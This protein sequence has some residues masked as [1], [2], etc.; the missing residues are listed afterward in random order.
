MVEALE[1]PEWVISHLTAI[2]GLVR[3][4]RAQ[5]IPSIGAAGTSERISGAADPSES[6]PLRVAALDEAD[7]LWAVMWEIVDEYLDRD[8]EECFCVLRNIGRMRRRQHLAVHAGVLVVRGYGSSASGDILVDTEALTGWMIRRAWRIALNL[9]HSAEGLVEMI[10]R[11]RT[12]TGTTST[13]AY[14]AQP[15]RTCGHRSVRAGWR[16]DGGGLAEWVCDNCEAR[17]TVRGRS[18]SGSG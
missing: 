4:L 16:E 9:P 11:L 17:E 2:P 6:A 18:E 5:R 3:E 12:V 13:R 15:C 8:R 7:Q 14:R 10:A 1:F